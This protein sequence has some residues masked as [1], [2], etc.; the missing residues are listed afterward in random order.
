MAV[1]LLTESKSKGYGPLVESLRKNGNLLTLTEEQ[2]KLVDE[3]DSNPEVVK[4]VRRLFAYALLQIMK[5]VIAQRDYL[6][7]KE[8][9]ESYIEVLIKL[10]LINEPAAL[11]QDQASTF[12][13]QC[14]AMLSAPVFDQSQVKE[15]QSKLKDTA[16][17]MSE[18]REKKKDESEGAEEC[19]QI[20]NVNSKEQEG[21][22]G[23]AVTSEDD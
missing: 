3:G 4:S 7:F 8:V 23:A 21:G 14:K 19:K 10:A 5:N 17:K 18:A 2:Q 16:K 12:D 20:A 9:D 1:K 13:D 15:M 11:E 6:Q 22:Q